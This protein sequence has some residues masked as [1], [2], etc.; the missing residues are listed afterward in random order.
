MGRSARRAGARL[1]GT[2]P[3]PAP[4]PR[5][6]RPCLVGLATLM[7]LVLGWGG[8]ALAGGARRGVLYGPHGV[9]ALTPRPYRVAAYLTG[10]ALGVGPLQ[11]P[12]GVWYQ[13]RTGTLYIADTGGNRVVVVPRR[14][15]AYA[16]GTRG[17]HALQG[18]TGVVTYQGFVLVADP[19]QGRIA[20]Y[21]PSGLFLRSLRLHSGVY[22]QTHTPF[23]PEQVAVSPLG[24]L[25]VL[26]R[27]T[28]RGLL[29]ST[30]T[31]HFL[32]FSAASPPHV[33]PL[34]S[35]GRTLL[36]RAQR[37]QLVP[38]YPSAP[39]G[40]AIGPGGFVFVT[41]PYR[42][43]DQIRRL[44]PAGGGNTLPG[45]ASTNYG[46][47]LT[48]GATAEIARF[49][50][51]A[52]SPSGFIAAGDTN[53]NR[54]FV[55]DAQGTPLFTFGGA[56]TGRGRFGALAGLAAGPH[57]ALFA[58]DRRLG[59]VQELVP[60]RFGR[61]VR[62]ASTLYVVGH[63]RQS[64]ATWRR[65]LLADNVY[66]LAL[67]GLGR[68]DL[69][70]GHPTRAM[71]RFRAAHDPAGYQVA[72]AVRQLRQER[73]DFGWLVVALGLLLGAVGALRAW[74]G[75]LWGWAWEL[76]ERRW[77]WGP[78]PLGFVRRVGAVLANPR[79]EFFA[80]KWMR[81]VGP[82]ETLGLMLWLYAVRLLSRLWTGY[83]FRPTGGGALHP[84]VLGLETFL[85]LAAWTLAS[86]AVADVLGGEGRL[87]EVWSTSLLCTIPYCLFGVPLALLSRW[88]VHGDAGAYGLLGLLVSAWVAYLF[89][90]QLLVVHDLSGR[91]VVRAVSWTSLALVGMAFTSAVV[92]GLSGRF[93]QF[94]GQV[95]RELT[96]LG[97]RPL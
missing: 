75:R 28:F 2:A 44:P 60:T 29:T 90:Q 17:G 86:Y 35:L 18:P 81:P 38:L 37:A 42:G 10:T 31:G 13:A 47:S 21:T 43:V 57:G 70:A 41:N 95:G 61:L 73:A 32:G 65:V 27:N 89:L 68:A 19:A 59:T 74:G 87:H 11:S 20:V 63:Y 56:G 93:A 83:A 30:L 88:L 49:G 36:T 50:P 24:I 40:V 26:N 85:P 33:G 53:G 15:P 14:A 62:H 23:A 25:Y 94:L 48:H 55:Y 80:V 8:A 97:W 84:V 91:E 58:L 64:A 82:V 77:R 52:V 46:Y 66:P 39:G 4:R 22:A 51:I 71:A 45:G 67:R 12:R 54:V 34:Q 16:I 72:H 9:A 7:L 78:N 79:E 3:R 6:L 96:A 92:L 76:A 5:G 1:G 69:A